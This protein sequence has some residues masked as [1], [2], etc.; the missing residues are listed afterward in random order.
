MSTVEQFRQRVTTAQSA[1]AD[2]IHAVNTERFYDWG[3]AT[4]ASL[5]DDSLLCSVNRMLD[6]ANGMCHA[7]NRATEST[8]QA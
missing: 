7:R 6:R 3:D 5:V 4:L 2:L 8:V 1:I